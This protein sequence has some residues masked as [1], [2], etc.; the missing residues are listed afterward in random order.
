MKPASLK[1]FGQKGGTLISNGLGD[2]F[3]GTHGQAHRVWPWFQGLIPL[4]FFSIIVLFE[5]QIRFPKPFGGFLGSWKECGSYPLNAGFQ[6]T[7]IS[8]REAVVQQSGLPPK[9]QKQL[10][11]ASLC[12]AERTLAPIAL[13]PRFSTSPTCKWR[14]MCKGRKGRT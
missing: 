5:N 9:P 12:F 11:W 3:L 1:G 13:K 2:R 8:W 4:P 14:G 10:F 6:S 7:R